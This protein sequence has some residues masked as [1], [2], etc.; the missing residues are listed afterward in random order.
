MT[1]CY[2]YLVVSIVMILR[3]GIIDARPGPP[4]RS[5]VMGWNTWCTTVEVGATPVAT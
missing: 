4:G 3:V 5:P 1:D 2:F